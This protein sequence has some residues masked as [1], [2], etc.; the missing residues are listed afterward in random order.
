MHLSPRCSARSKRDGQPCRQPATSK[1]RCRMHGGAKGSGAP[2][3]PR[4]G[5]WRHGGR[6]SQVLAIRVMERLLLRM[7]RAAL[8]N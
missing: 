5:A 6:S 1:G 3:G 2:E 4:N 8:D 7:A